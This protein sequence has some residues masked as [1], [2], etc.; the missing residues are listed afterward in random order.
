MVRSLTHEG[1]SLLTFHRQKQISKFAF[2]QDRLR[3]W[4]TDVREKI[5]HFSCI[6]LNMLDFDGFRI[7]KALQVTV[8]A[9]GEWSNYMRECARKLGKENFYI[10]GE[11]VAGNTLGAIYIGRGKEP[12]MQVENI[13]EVLTFTNETDPKF[14]IREP[15]K[16]GLDAA[17]F[18]YTIYRALTRFL[19]LDGIYAAEGDPPV[20]FVETW[21]SILQTNDLVNA[22]TGKF[23]P[24]RECPLNLL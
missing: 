4:R 19:G 21:N 22:N 17:A 6:A 5:E 20:N 3:E 23:D 9:Q 1:S 13:T 8:D 16:A 18:H 24:R 14:F 15:E 2:V 12:S 11:I 7:D 10:P